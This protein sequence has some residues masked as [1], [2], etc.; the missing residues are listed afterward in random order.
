MRAR[1]VSWVS[2]G[3]GKKRGKGRAN[4][5]CRIGLS[6][7]FPG[8]ADTCSNEYFFLD[9]FKHG[10]K[11]WVGR[12]RGDDF[13]LGG[14]AIKFFRFVGGGGSQRLLRSPFSRHSKAA[15]RFRG[16]RLSLPSPGRRQVYWIRR[17]EGRA[18][19]LQ[20]NEYFNSMALFRKTVPTGD[21]RLILYFF[22]L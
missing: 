15:I 14:L 22:F 1:S 6:L 9:T 17:S 12:R 5:T 8:Q 4:S 7:S 11:R 13:R 2:T 21:S 19:Y 18:Y 20:R 10:F 3:G 16:P